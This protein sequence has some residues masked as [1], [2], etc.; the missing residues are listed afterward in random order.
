[1]DLGRPELDVCAPETDQL[2][3]DRLAGRPFRLATTTS[4]R[5]LGSAREHRDP[6]ACGDDDGRPARDDR[7]HLRHPPNPMKVSLAFLAGVT[8]AMVLETTIYYLLASTIELGDPSD[9]ASSGTIIQL[10]L[11][12][13]LAL[14]ALRTYRHR[15]D[16]RAPQVAAA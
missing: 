16:Y 14:L 5:W 4:V 7:D 1:M 3:I 12:G 13:L 2:A 8:A 15:R 6:P 9:T 10:V 11:A